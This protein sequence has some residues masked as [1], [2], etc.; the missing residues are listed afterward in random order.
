MGNIEFIDA[1]T[2][3]TTESTIQPEPRLHQ[4]PPWV[5]FYNEIR[6]L[7]QEDHEVRISIEGE[8]RNVK[9]YVENPFKAEAI[10]AILPEEKTFGDITV[11]VTV[12]PANEKASPA[13][14]YKVAFQGNPVITRFI[15]RNDT[16]FA[17][18][19]YVV[20]R[21][22]VVQFYDDNLADPY[23]NRSTLF[24]DIARDVFEDNLAIRYATDPRDPEPKTP[25]GTEGYD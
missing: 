21:K 18:M 14:Y 15:T 9:L 5:T 17:G 12:I 4:S 20:F 19:T 3:A 16:M 7:F 25:T 11:T 8:K 24:E 23:G 10:R 2:T 6:Q 1:E 13:D 22:E